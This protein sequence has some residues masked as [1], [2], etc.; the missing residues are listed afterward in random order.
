M[1]RN[2]TKINKQTKQKKNKTQEKTSDIQCNCSP[3]AHGCPS[4]DPPL[5]ANSPSLYTEHDV[6]WY[7][8]SLWLVQVS[9]P[10]HAPSQLL[11]HLLAGRDWETEKSLAWD[12]RN[13]ATTK[14][15][16]CYQHYSHTKS[17]THC[18]SY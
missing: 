7:G 8:I 5:L 4:S 15:L 2:I 16:V 6:L 17:K 1:R 18:T 9:C 13:L 12:K 3:P 10:G 11:V 14:T